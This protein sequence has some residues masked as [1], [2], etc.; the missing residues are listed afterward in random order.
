MH[1]V[2]THEFR[3]DEVGDATPLA[4]ISR[5]ADLLQVLDRA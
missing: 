2:L 4:V 1:G 3:Q 5:L